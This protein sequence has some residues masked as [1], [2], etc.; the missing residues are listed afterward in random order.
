[1]L[2]PT[3]IADLP[4]SPRPRRV[5]IIDHTPFTEI[6]SRFHRSPGVVGGGAGQGLSRPSSPAPLDTMEVERH[7]EPLEVTND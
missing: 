2:P 7:S 1:M 4:K 5:A 6:L 3:G